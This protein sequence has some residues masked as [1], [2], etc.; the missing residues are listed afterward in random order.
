MERP[1][2]SSRTRSELKEGQSLSAD[3][4]LERESFVVPPNLILP[5]CE[6]ITPEMLPLVELDSAQIRGIIQTVP[7]GARNIQDI[8]PLAPL[9]EGILFHHLVNVQRGDTYV[10]P[11]LLSLSSREKLEEFVGALQRVLDRHDILRSAVLWDQLPRPVQVVY[12]RATL[13]VEELVLDPRHDQIEQITERMR[14]ERQSLDLRRAP[15]LRL[16]VVADRQGTQWYAL[17]QLHHLVCDGQSL[18][19][20]IA[21]VRAILEGRERSL[22]E[23]VAYRRHVAQAL[24]YTQT[25][26]VDAFFRQTLSEIDEP[27]APFGVLDVHSGGS[28]IGEAH[29]AVEPELARRLRSQARRLTL[30]VA[31][32]IHAAWALVVSRT[33]GRNDVV[34]GTVLL[35]R[36]QASVGVR[37]TVGMFINTLPLRSRLQG[38][39]VKEL[40]EQTQVALLDLLNHEQ[41]SLAVARRCSGIPGSAPLFSTLLNYRHSPRNH[42]ADWTANAE[43]RVLAHQEWTN[44]PVTLSVDD[45]GE[46]FSVTAQTDKRIDPNRVTSYMQTAMQSIVE[47]LEM[48]P[49]TPVLA[50]SILPERER[51]QIMESFNA[52]RTVYSHEKL[53]HQLF[54]EQA[55][56]TPDAIAVVCQ[57]NSWTYRDLN[58]RAN[59]LARYLTSRG[60]G[61]DQLVALCVNRSAEMVVGLLGILK[62]GG[63]YVPL[64]PTSPT[65]R[66]RYML[67]D[68]A[69]RLVLAEDNFRAVLPVTQAHLVSL[70]TKLREIAEYVDENLSAAELALSPQHLVYVIYTSGSTGRPK[71]VAMAHSSLVNLIDWHRRTFDTTEGLRVLQFAPLGFDV[72]FQETFSTL[73][74]GGTLVLLDEWLRREPLALIDFLSRESIQRLFVPPMVLQSLAE[75]SKSSSVDLG[76]LQDVITAGEQLRISPEISKFFKRHESC[77]L[78]NHY[79]PTESHVVTALTLTGDPDAWPALP[80]VGRPISNTQI[81]VLDEHGQP[82]PIGVTGEIYIGGVGVARG[83]LKRPELT[84]KRFINNPFRGASG[85]TLYRT[86]DLA[87]YGE[88]GTLEY[89]GRNDHQVKIRGYRIELGEIEAQLSLHEQVKEAVVI[90]RE[91]VPG[92]KRIVAYITQRSGGAVDD[93]R[94]RLKALLPEYMIPSAFVILESLPRT[95]NGKLDRSALPAPKFEVYANGEYESPQGE[96]EAVL[97]GIWQ[98]VLRLDRVGRYD[99]FFSLGGHS[100]TGMRLIARVA[101]SFNIQVPVHMVFR[102]PTIH[103]MAQLVESV[104]SENPP[105]S[106]TLDFEEHTI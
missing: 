102:H 105:A 90:A 26:D 1:I 67:E 10:L 89:L 6:M 5:E 54:E 45:L 86:G 8:Y 53:V 51:H 38:V 30:S 55:R 98:Q 99:N 15:L 78:H 35:G 62:A 48:A 60:V 103:E 91:D 42:E 58:R 68:A 7:G 63:A 39:T 79:G 24:A 50:L 95:P 56:R 29:L 3:L 11:T 59:Q 96:I 33:S 92:D 106:Q 81:Y 65:E 70:D 57:Q 97:G 2:Y 85:K 83:Y 16:Q 74:T 66:L 31:T 40:V 36:M 49:E 32:L 13:P 17:L 27:T 104:L 41:A 23:P 80:T 28:R 61:P 20:V 19:T 12:R 25:H 69:P 18:A 101:E 22:P 9:Q 52:T 34:F 84:V 71:G 37:R 21:E 75:F 93:L 44:Y 72:S 77:R 87:R 4:E 73:C 46:G 88:D 43:I 82:V 64:D 14:P 94:A 76:S 100:M 47:T